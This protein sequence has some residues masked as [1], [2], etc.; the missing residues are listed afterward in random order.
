[1][2]ATRWQDWY[3]EVRRAHD[4]VASQCDQVFAGGLSMGGTLATKLAQDL[5]D[6]ISGLILVNAAYGTLRKD[7]A[8]AKYISWALA[9]RPGI[10]SDIKKQGVAEL[11]YDKTPLKAFV[12]LQQLWQLVVPDLPKVT[13]PVLYF[14]SREDHVVDALSGQ[15]L[16]A[17]ATST[18]VTEIPLENSYHVATMDNDAEQIFTGT[19]DFIREHSRTGVSD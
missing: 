12:S 1:M 4:E 2:N 17:G 9:S 13:A 7:A 19:V 5:G 16:H 14:H 10:G 6:Q 3:A 18:S 15:L 11:A 8:L